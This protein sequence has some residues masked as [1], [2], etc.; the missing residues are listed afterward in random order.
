LEEVSRIL[1]E[2]ATAAASLFSAALAASVAV[3]V[4]VLNQAFSR[5]Q[6]RV[7]FRQPKLEE[8]Y[9]LI[10]EVG[11]RNTRL[12]KLLM[13]I[14]EGDIQAKN[15]LNSID[16]L[17]VY[18]HPTAKRMVMLVQLYFPKL[19][20][21]HQK[22]F[23]AERELSGRVWSLH[24]GEAVNAADIV[25]SSGRVAHMLRLM[26]QEMVENQEALLQSSVLPMR[27]RAV[28]EREISSIPPPPVG[29]PLSMRS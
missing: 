17:E 11:E 8:L 15:H 29:P 10:N 28:S 4:L 6:Q 22:L 16:D 21:I 14:A 7:Q 2:H 5:R 12:F 25:E 26:E 3:L 20:R 9:L 27:Y 18:G 1:L 24:M 19:T 23:A 13:A